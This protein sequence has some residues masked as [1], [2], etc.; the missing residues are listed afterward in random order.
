MSNSTM[1]LTQTGSG[2]VPVDGQKVA[3]LGVCSAGTAEELVELEPSQDVAAALGYGPLCEAA[4]QGGRLSR[5]RSLAMK[6]AT[7]TP[8]TFGSVTATGQGSGPLIVVVAGSTPFDTY[9]VRA[10]VT[11][12]GLPGA[13]RIAV[14]LD[15][16][17]YLYEYDIPATVPARVTG[18]VD[19]N[20]AGIVA[21]LDGLTLVTTT[22]VSTTTFDTDGSTT[23]QELVDQVQDAFTAASIA[24]RALLYQGK[25]L[26]IETLAGGSSA[27][28]GV[29]ASSTGEVILGM[30]TTP[31][32]GAPARLQLPATNLTLEFP[33][34][35][36]YVLNAVYA[37]NT[38]APRM[39][40]ADV[41]AGLAA[42]KD[43]GEVFGFVHIVQEPVNASELRAWVDQ[44]D[45]V[46]AGWKSADERLSTH[47]IIGAPVDATDA[48]L[49]DE[50]AG[51]ASDYAVVAAGD[52]YT[53]GSATLG[54]HRRSSSW[55]LAVRRAAIELSRDP[56]DGDA[57]S[58]PECKLVG[59]DG[60]L[61]RNENTATIKLLGN[62]FTVI[63][64]YQKQPYFC[65]GRTRAGTSSLFADIGVLAVGNLAFNVASAVAEAKANTILKANPDGTIVEFLRGQLESVYRDA[66]EEQVL[67]PGHASAVFVAINPLP[68]AT[69]NGGGK[70][71]KVAF[72][73]QSLIQVEGF[74]GVVTITQTLEQTVA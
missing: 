56:G 5:R 47:Y 34:T 62:G 65:R 69:G 16:G 25:F 36:A 22:L 29:N 60:A 63:R 37:F 43:A 12:G 68:V 38:T 54:S 52:I 19:L 40:L 32:T 33:A 17:N 73:V 57:K 10:K 6:I 59:P 48:D 27:A 44:L 67:R 58:L 51:H 24:A 42:L 41:L 14:A 31:A 7:T 8:G 2:V 9:R 11:R 23:P 4:R 49:R 20:G 13:G 64:S 3:R 15:G 53:T 74:D 50:M 66:L 35:S 71:V 70:R 1:E 18:T 61:A 39:S 21:S 46:F 26:R 72:T 55:P 28:I 45:A 30:S